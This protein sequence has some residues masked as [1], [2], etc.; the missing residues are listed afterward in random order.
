[1]GNVPTFSMTMRKRTTDG[2][3][4]TNQN[5]RRVIYV[6]KKMPSYKKRPWVSFVRK[7]N[8]VIESGLGTKTVLFNTYIE[9][10][11]AANLQGILTIGFYGGTGLADAPPTGVANYCGLRDIGVMMANDPMD[12]TGSMK[13][14]SA[15]LDVTYQAA[16]DNQI[17]TELDVY[18]LWFSNQDCPY[19]NVNAIFQAA[20]SVTSNISGTG[21]GLNITTRGV[22]P[23]DLP[24][25]FKIAKMSVYKKTKYLLAPGEAC[26]YQIRDPRMH[27]FNK[28]DILDNLANDSM[29]P[30]KRVMRVLYS[31]FKP[32]VGSAS[33]VTLTAG[34]TRKYAYYVMESN[35][36]GDQRLP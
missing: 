9:D 10:T 3:G 33:T 23:F 27:E 11:N 20:A 13:I 29:V 35:K 6:K 4:V 19:T 15:I 12:A 8:R 2:L 1:M 22:T 34:V 31:I 36:S 14:K 7:V 28:Y 25:A 16:L 21:T 30:G 32:V 17:R 5:D 26:T 18:E 24:E